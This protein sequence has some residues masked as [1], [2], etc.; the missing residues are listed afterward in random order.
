MFQIF[1]DVP[2]DRKRI[3]MLGEHSLTGRVFP[4]SLADLI[5]I[6]PGIMDVTSGIAAVERLAR[7]LKLATLTGSSNAH[8]VAL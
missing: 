7:T 8:N 3:E 1:N 6:F 5:L 2:C 4:L